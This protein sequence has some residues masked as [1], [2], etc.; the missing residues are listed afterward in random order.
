MQNV[1]EE[2]NPQDISQLKSESNEQ[3]TSSPSPQEQELLQYNSN[4]IIFLA[5]LEASMRYREATWR[6]DLLIYEQS[7]RETIPARMDAFKINYKTKFNR[8][9]DGSTLRNFSR[10]IDRSIKNSVDVVAQ[11]VNKFNK[12]AYAEIE[13]VTKA[14]SKV[15]QVSFDN[16][17]TGFGVLMEEFVKAKNTT[18]FLTICKLYN[19]GAMDKTLEI[20]NDIDKQETKE[21]AADPEASEEILP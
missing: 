11:D 2:G 21:P 19:S 8:E 1:K 5:L 15:G 12:I 4:K 16:Y 6:E 18:H 13:K 9:P 14:M 17:A 20:L 7:L 10:D 3:E